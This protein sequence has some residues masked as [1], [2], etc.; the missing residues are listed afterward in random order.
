MMFRYFMDME[1]TMRDVR[2]T[3]A[4]IGVQRGLVRQRIA[5][6]AWHSRTLRHYV[7]CTG[8]FQSSV[9]PAHCRCRHRCL[10]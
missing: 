2:G 1:C 5:S 8:L 7:T 6:I 3:V 4:D 9:F 10:H